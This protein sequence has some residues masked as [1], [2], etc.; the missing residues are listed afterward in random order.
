MNR[1]RKL[2]GDMPRPASAHPVRVGFLL[3]RGGDHMPRRD[4]IWALLLGAF[5]GLL[6]LFL[7]VSVLLVGPVYW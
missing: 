4:W 6:L 2:N 1:P 3:L 5:A 7:A